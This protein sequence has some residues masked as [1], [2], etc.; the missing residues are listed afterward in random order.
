MISS[1]D[2][3]YY[4]TMHSYSTSIHIPNKNIVSPGRLL[5]VTVFVLFISSTSINNIRFRRSYSFVASGLVVRLSRLVVPS[6]LHVPRS[7]N[8]AP[9]CVPTENG[10]LFNQRPRTG[11]KPHF[12]VA[13]H[14]SCFEHTLCGFAA[15][16]GPSQTP[17]LSRRS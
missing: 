7:C 17:C 6:L 15:R 3:I 13:T 9:T 10:F 2:I 4:C 11:K 16:R 12:T 14:T 8:P 1:I 5:C